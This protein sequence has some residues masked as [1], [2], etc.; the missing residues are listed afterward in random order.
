MGDRLKNY[1]P[2]TI[3][4]FYIEIR[5]CERYL[6]KYEKEIVLLKSSHSNYIEWNNRL[7]ETHNLR[8][9]LIKLYNRYMILLNKSN[10]QKLI[11]IYQ[12]KMNNS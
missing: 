9:K 7:M 6:K 11:L 4:E 2:E 1:K 3:H 12:S 10:K 5:I 8:R